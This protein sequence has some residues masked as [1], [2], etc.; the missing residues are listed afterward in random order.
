MILCSIH[1]F[2]RYL[3][4]NSRF[5]RLANAMEPARLSTLEKGRRDIAGE[6]LF[7][8]A[9][10]DAVTR[11]TAMLEAHRKY[12]DVHVLLEGTES[13]GWAPLGTLSV[14]DKPFDVENDFVCF[15]DPYKCTFALEP[16]TI[17]VFF[18]EDAHA[19]LLGNGHRVH[20]CVFKVLVDP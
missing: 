12:I 15:R 19:P 18:P 7:V 13:M 20:K 5:A 6:E 8:I 16:R 17:A 9:S 2:R 4:Q 14:E 3:G 10:P 11:E 1:E